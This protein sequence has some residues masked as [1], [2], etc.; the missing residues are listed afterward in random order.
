M[1]AKDLKA[2][3]I[4]RTSDPVFYVRRGKQGSGDT[5]LRFR[6]IEFDKA[7]REKYVKAELAHLGGTFVRVA[8][9]AKVRKVA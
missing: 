3:D 7:T 8:I 4:F 1:T 6:S 2:G 9:D 5:D